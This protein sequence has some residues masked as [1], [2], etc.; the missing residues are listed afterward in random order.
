M[1]RAAAFI[2][3]HV[4]ALPQRVIRGRRQVR[5]C[6]CRKEENRGGNPRC[7]RQE[8]PGTAA[9]EDLLCGSTRERTEAAALPR[10]QEHDEDQEQARDNVDNDKGGFEKLTHGVAKSCTREA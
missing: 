9:T 5:E 10:L 1:Q 4:A 2:I 7:F 6:H 3:V 8:V